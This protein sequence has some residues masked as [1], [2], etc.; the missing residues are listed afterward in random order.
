MAKPLPTP[1]KQLSD[2]GVLEKYRN[3]ILRFVAQCEADFSQ[4]AFSHLFYT[5]SNFR[6]FLRLG[7]HKR[8]GSEIWKICL[9]E[10]VIEGK[11]FRAELLPRKSGD[12]Y[13][14]EV[15]LKAD[16]EWSEAREEAATLLGSKAV[17]LISEQ[18]EEAYRWLTKKEHLGRRWSSKELREKFKFD[19]DRN[20]LKKLHLFNDPRIRITKEGYWN[21]EVF[22]S[23]TPLPEWSLPPLNPVFPEIPKEFS[24]SHLELLRT[25]LEDLILSRLDEG[26][27]F[28]VFRIGTRREKQFCFPRTQEDSLESKSYA[29]AL[30]RMP[31]IRGV[32]L[33]YSFSAEMGPWYCG[34]KLLSGY[35]WDKVRSG[36]RSRRSEQPPEKKYGLSGEASKVLTWFLDQN[37]ESFER[38][39]SPEVEEC[40]ALEIGIDIED[41]GEKNLTQLFHLICHEISE[42]TEFYAKVVP[43]ADEYHDPKLHLY[44]RQKRDLEEIALSSVQHFLRQQGAEPTREEILQ[45][46]Q[47]LTKQARD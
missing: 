29:S 41:I 3:A 30:Y 2:E 27:I 33:F 17:S 14:L 43:W 28:L 9:S 40:L 47:S 25:F 24:R 12:A 46:L 19:P 18:V 13:D 45:A 22:V 15:S 26:D 23:E 20:L 1:R 5:Q 35:T 31:E 32:S 16:A 8:E 10:P 37:Y 7:P 4:D 44:F 6:G 21:Y 11:T 38:H 34:L 39:L 36:I 42:K